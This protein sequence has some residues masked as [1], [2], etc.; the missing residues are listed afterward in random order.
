MPVRKPTASLAARDLKNEPW[1]Q[2][3]KMMNT[4]T[5]SAPNKIA[6]GT[7]SHHEIGRLKYI[8]YHKAPIGISVA[9]ISHNARHVDGFWYLATTSFQ[10]SASG[11]PCPPAEFKSSAII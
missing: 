7:T 1:P 4:R 10:A 5:S 3:W 6:S 11:L 9:T 8:R 2:S